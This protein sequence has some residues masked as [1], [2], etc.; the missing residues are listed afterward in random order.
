MN[1]KN[2]SNIL[3]ISYTGKRYITV[4]NTKYLAPYVICNTCITCNLFR[5]FKLSFEVR[6]IFNQSYEV[7]A[8]YPMPGREYRAM[9][10]F[11]E[12]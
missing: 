3:E 7:M 8:G 12:N 4:A 6:N 10:I 5:R 11:G 1:Y 9:I 2:L